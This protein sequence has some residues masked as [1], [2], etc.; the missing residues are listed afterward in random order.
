[1][2]DRLYATWKRMAAVAN[3]TLPDKIRTSHI[4]RMRSKHTLDLL[5]KRVVEIEKGVKQR[6][7][8]PERRDEMQKAIRKSTLADY[9]RFIDEIV[10]RMALAEE[11]ACVL[12]LLLC[13]WWHA[14]SYIL[15]RHRLFWLCC[16]LR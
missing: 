13:L 2:V 1:M 11:G 8:W 6:P 9:W 7:D 10:D 4:E 15:C 5:E 3:A 12:Q 16:L 14:R